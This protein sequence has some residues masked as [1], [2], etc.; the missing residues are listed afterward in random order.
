[1][2]D[3][4]EIRQSVI[5]AASAGDLDACR[6]YLGHRDV[7]DQ[8]RARIYCQLSEALYHKGSREVAVE[9]ARSAFDLH[10]EKEEIANLCAWVF[11]NCGKHE[12]A[13]AAYEQL[14]AIRP[15]WAAGH[16]HASG[17][18]AAAGQ[19]D[20]AIS[21]GRKASD[22]EPQSFE[23]AF[24]AAC[25]L[26]TVGRPA[27]AADYLMRAA[28]L[29]PADA[30]VLRHLSATLF[31]L[32][33]SEQAVALAL[34]AVALAP[35]DRLNTLH[36]TE[37]L[38]RT[39]RY[40]EAAA[41]ILDVVD[42]HREDPVALRLLSATQMLRG[43]TEDALAA[44]DRALDLSPDAAEYHLHRANLLYRL[45][46][47]DEA[48]ET[49]GRSAA[50]D[51]SNQDAKR[52]Q[53]TVY[54]DSGR[55]IEALVIGGEL[56]RTSPDNEEYAQAILQVLHRRLD[57]I[58]GD[59]VVLSE[60]PLRPRREPRP[61]PTI[62]AALQTQLRVVYAL[63]IRETRT[64]L[65]ESKLGYGWALLEP[66]LHILMLS[67]VFAVMMRGR[68]PI[69]DKFFIFYY[70]GII[71]YHL[72]VHTSSSMTN[73]VSSSAALLQLPLVSTFDVIMARGLVE[74]LTDVIVAIMLL[75]G[76]FAIGIG[77]LPRNLPALS[78]SVIAVSL[79]GC[80]IGFISAVINAFVKS[81]DKIWAQLT[82][83]LYFCSGIFRYYVACATKPSL[84][85]AGLA[86]T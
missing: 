53:L 80:G 71:P 50:L 62:F 73:A 48:A 19:F 55:F 30:E 86:L 40:D 43:L 82:R 2:N 64:R 76:F 79:F 12:E 44:I 10:P 83:A 47:L 85:G 42:I 84:A 56:I 14:L 13:A 1:L 33:Q 38:L 63:M 61:R 66:V 23:F 58:D 52:S 70:T 69:G 34:R 5:G 26:E 41:I 8:E 11:S 57:M 17:S 49:F 60:R 45:G 28:A 35:S 81:W 46:R 39:N 72:F 29:D 75:A 21:H 20:R 59:Y 74:V 51:P 3:L 37:L 16:R 78:A 77:L 4:G 31:A 27:Q 18:F 9:C 22:L 7:P 32:D 36:A 24:H 54:F 68:P 6:F 15:H 25:L 65:A 67:L